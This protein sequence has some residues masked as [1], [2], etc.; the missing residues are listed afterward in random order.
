MKHSRTCLKLN[1]IDITRQIGVVDT[2]IVVKTDKPDCVWAPFAFVS[3]FYTMLY[4][5]VYNYLSSG[6]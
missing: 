2:F 3:I 1:G 6:F 5:L 4:I